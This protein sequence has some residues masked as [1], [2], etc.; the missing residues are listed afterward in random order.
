MRRY[1]VGVADP[2]RSGYSRQKSGALL[3]SRG[4]AMSSKTAGASPRSSN[5]DISEPRSGDVVLVAHT[6]SQLRSSYGSFTLFRGLAPAVTDNIGSP[7]LINTI[8]VAGKHRKAMF[9][10][11]FMHA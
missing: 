2:R 6:T 1:G 7:T 10:Q 9:L 4:A 8:A 3:R 11:G 5:T